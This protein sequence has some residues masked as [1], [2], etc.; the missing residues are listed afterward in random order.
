[1]D[2]LNRLLYIATKKSFRFLGRLPKSAREYGAVC[3]GR[4]LFAVDHKH[5]RIAVDNLSRAFGREKSRPQIVAIA[6]EVFVNLFRITFETAWSLNLPEYKFPEYFHI[7]GQSEFQQAYA[8]GKGVLLLG[9]HFGN[10]EVQMIIAHMMDMPLHVVVRT[11]DAAFLDRFVEGYRSRFGAV[12]IPN[13]RAAMRKIYAALKKGY[14]VGILMDQSADFD[15][16]VFVD[17]FSHRAAT[18][19]GMAVLALKSGAPVLPFFLIRRPNG[20]QAVL[21]PELPL[22]KT[23]DSTKDIEENT[24]LYNHVIEAYVRRFPDQWFWVHQ[25]WKNLPFCPWPRTNPRVSNRY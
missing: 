5:R 10:W 7:Q 2:P 21:G 16:G 4:L 24:Q 14:P 22:I 1:M 20:F 9:A 3:L 19:T 8:K 6:R 13:Q 15:D 12:M 18:N 25:R 17:F 23:G 11:L